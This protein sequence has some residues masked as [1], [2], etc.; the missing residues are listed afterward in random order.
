MKFTKTKPFLSVIVVLVAVGAVVAVLRS[1]INQNNSNKYDAFATC[2]KE[3]GV[4]FYGASWCPHC[5]AEKK[6]F[7]SS[8]RILNY[9]ECATSKGKQTQFCKDQKIMSY[10]T[11]EFADGSRI[12][13]EISLEILAQKTSCVL[14]Q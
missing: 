10:P 8:A 1:G 4:I 9:V 3:K 5:Q 2:L 13:S 6:L 14:P 11:W 7:G 12:N